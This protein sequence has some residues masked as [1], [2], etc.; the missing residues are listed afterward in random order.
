MRA[1]PNAILNAI[2]PAVRN[3][4]ILH[5]AGENAERNTTNAS[6]AMIRVT[7]PNATPTNIIVLDSE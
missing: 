7:T 1:P 5:F 2:Y 3:D 6:S 4:A